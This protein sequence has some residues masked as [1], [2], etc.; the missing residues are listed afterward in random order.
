MD[1]AILRA[2][3]HANRLLVIPA[4]G[5]GS[6]L[7][8][9]TPKILVRVA[10]RPMIDHLLVIYRSW[11]ASAVVVAHPSFAGTLRE[12]LRDRGDSSDVDV[13]EQSARTGMLDAVLLAADAV[14]RRKPDEV[15]I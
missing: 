4:A 14:A 1:S 11:I 9:G 15:W 8:G 12:H 5:A 6:R 7:G 2:R 10:G 3:M 13:V